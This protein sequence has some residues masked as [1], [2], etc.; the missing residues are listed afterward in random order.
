MHYL[1]LFCEK[2]NHKLEKEYLYERKTSPKKEWLNPDK[3]S[4]VGA[5]IIAVQAHLSPR[6]RHTPNLLP[7]TSE[8][9][10]LVNSMLANKNKQR[11]IFRT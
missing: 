2:E 6:C 7:P 5:P 10:Q 4:G 11:K 8:F 3:S 1:G 9:Q